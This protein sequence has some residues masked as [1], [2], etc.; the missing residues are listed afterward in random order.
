MKKVF[1]IAE[2]GVNHNGD[3]SIAKKMID[4]AKAAGAGAIKFQA[5]RAE[6]IVVKEAVK[7][8]YQIKNTG[9]SES[10]LDM[11]KRLE[12]SQ[13][14]FRALM[15][16][17]NKKGIMFMATPFDCESVE[18]LDRLGMEVFK[19]SS[20]EIT[21]KFLIESVARK[22]KPIILSTGM[23]YLEEVKKAVD[24]IN[25]VWE[26]LGKRP[27]LT[28]LHCVSNYPADAKDANLKAMATLK[29]EFD[30]PVGY[31][32]HTLGIDIAIAAAAMGAVVIEK[33]FTLDRNMPGPDH[34]ASLEPK[35]LSAMV[36]AIR[37][38]EKAM[39]DGKK[40]P[41]ESERDTRRFARKSLVAARDIKAGQTIKVEDITIKRPGDGL[42]PYTLEEIIN[43]K[44]RIDIPQ[45]SMLQKDNFIDE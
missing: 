12:L 18:L 27:T 26:K 13:E 37:N 45:D 10:Q 39:G 5:F 35:E 29:K 22:N 16:Y 43:K 7:A 30:L 11:L 34:K 1:I 32:D 9:N 38:V 21:N 24:A 41:Q 19:I 23:S 3:I 4:E 36:E 33:H 6:N 25:A 20:G 44:A 42:S 14:D 15:T 28:L 17:C 40:V 31:S 8:E 2:A